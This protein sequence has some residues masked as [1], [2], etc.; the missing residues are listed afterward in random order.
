MWR[1]CFSGILRPMGFARFDDLN[2]FFL[3]VLSEVTIPWIIN[4][5]FYR[6]GSLKHIPCA[7]CLLQE[8]NLAWIRNEIH[9][10]A[11][12]CLQARVQSSWFHIYSTDGRHRDGWGDG[13]WDEWWRMTKRM[14]Q[15]DD[16]PRILYILICTS[17][18]ELKLIFRLLIIL[19]T[20]QHKNWPL[21]E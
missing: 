4:S 9:T 13:W 16:H 21:Q 2:L 3:V 1:F 18:N 12:C 8:T 20:W 17:L 14:D 15:K 19:N 10:V 7:L 11:S 5:Y 6:Q